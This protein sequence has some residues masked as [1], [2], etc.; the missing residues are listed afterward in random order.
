VDWA[1]TSS[2]FGGTVY[3]SGT[4]SNPANGVVISDNAYGYDVDAELVT[5]SGVSVPAGT[6]WLELSN[7]VTAQGNAA[8]WDESD[9]PSSAWQLQVGN[10]PASAIS[11]ETFTLYAAQTPEPSSFL[12]LGSGLAGLAGMIRRKI[13]A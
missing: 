9:G 13:K 2:A 11:S 1:F 5:I 4:Q 3:G 12:L 10:P 6:S 8:F 7:G